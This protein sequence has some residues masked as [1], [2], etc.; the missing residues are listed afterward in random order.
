MSELNLLTYAE[1]LT[2][3]PASQ[4]YA[5]YMQAEWPGSELKAH[6]N[7]PYAL[8]SDEHAQWNEGAQVACMNVQDGEE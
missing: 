7:N 8:G 2:L 1:Y 4:G 5:V 3:S 6:E